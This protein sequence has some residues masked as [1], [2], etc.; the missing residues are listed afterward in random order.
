MKQFS[1]MFQDQQ[2]PLGVRHREQRNH[3]AQVSL[4]RI[5]LRCALS[6]NRFCNVCKASNT[7]YLARSIK[8]KERESES[9]NRERKRA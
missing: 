6:N 1:K 9:K 8:K 3:R 2:F 4:S 5:W 7:E